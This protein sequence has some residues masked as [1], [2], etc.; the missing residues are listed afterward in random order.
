MRVYVETNFVLELALEQEQHESC[1]KLLELAES[2]RVEIVVPAYSLVEPYETFERRRRKRK[3]IHRDI[4]DELKQLIRSAGYAER[5]DGFEGIIDLLIDSASEESKRLEDVRARLLIA[6]E[7][8]SLD[9]ECLSRAVAIRAAYDLSP[10]DSVVY[11]AVLSHLD[12]SAAVE[13]CF[14]TRDAGDFREPR[15][16]AELRERRCMLIPRFDHGLQLVRSRLA[17]AEGDG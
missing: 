10:Q 17:S 3:L 8:V 11:A 1:A 5:L 15:L 13:C 9:T 12:R 16:L 14:L 4:D 6:C 2:K 7:V